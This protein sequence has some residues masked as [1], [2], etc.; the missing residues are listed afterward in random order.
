MW[1][2]LCENLVGQRNASGLLLSRLVRWL[3][4]LSSGLQPSCLFALTLSCLLIELSPASEPDARSRLAVERPSVGWA[5][6]SRSIDSVPAW[7][8]SAA[9]R[10]S[11]AWRKA[12]IRPLRELAQVR[13]VDRPDGVQRVVPSPDG[14]QVTTSGRRGRVLES[15][16]RVIWLQDYNTRVV[17]LGTTLGMLLANA[18]V[19]WFGERITRLIPLQWVHRV[20]AAIFLILGALILLGQDSDAQPPTP[21][22]NVAP[23]ASP[24][25]DA[26][27]SARP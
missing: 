10:R 1:L 12:P 4:S 7:E 24:T 21:A 5:A 18:P 2:V 26:S 13:R 19:V 8:S 22:P 15:W 27:A 17:V 23:V 3:A 20:S 25:P 11:G 16:Q 14:L 6:R 9:V